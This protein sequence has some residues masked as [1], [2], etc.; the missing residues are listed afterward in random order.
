[1]PNWKVTYLFR[2]ATSGWTES[3]YVQNTDPNPTLLAVQINTVLRARFTC[4]GQGVF[5]QGTRVVDDDNPGLSWPQPLPE[6][7]GNQY[8]PANEP[9]DNPTSCIDARFNAGAFQ[10]HRIM[11]MRGWP[12]LWIYRHPISLNMGWTADA[13]TGMRFYLA[14][15]QTARFLMKVIDKDPLSVNAKPVRNVTWAGGLTTITSPAHGFA[16][17]DSI[18]VSKVKGPTAPLVAKG[19][20]QIESVTLNDF[21]FPAPDPGVPIIYTKGGIVRRRRMTYVRIDEGY[22]FRVS[23][24]DTGRAFFLPLGRRR[25]P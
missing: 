4:L 12:D 15:L 19:V 16:A 11:N 23:K 14:A 24:R 5:T 18:R 17:G 6:T 2:A 13:E 21:S 3:W 9:A 10:Y 1:M 25:R 20:Y 8:Q 7:Y 22:L